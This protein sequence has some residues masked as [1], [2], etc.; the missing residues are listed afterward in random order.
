MWETF[1]VAWEDEINTMNGIRHTIIG[2]SYAHYC[3][4]CSNNNVSIKAERVEQQLPYILSVGALRT[5][6]EGGRTRVRADVT[7]GRAQI[8]LPVSA[9]VAAGATLEVVV[10]VFGGA[11]GGGGG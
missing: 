11:R 8:N 3:L 2:L 1:S 10:V 4:L 5:R 7:G 6:S 9:A